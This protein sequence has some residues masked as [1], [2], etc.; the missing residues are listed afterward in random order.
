MQYLSS[1]RDA[2]VERDECILILILDSRFS[3]PSLIFLILH[4]IRS[5]VQSSIFHAGSIQVTKGD[6][7]TRNVDQAI[8][9]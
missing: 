4:S 9:V 7:I 3:T 8:V 2:I 6:I 5:L 1:C